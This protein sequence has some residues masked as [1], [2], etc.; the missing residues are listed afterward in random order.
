MGLFLV[1]QVKVV[2][3]GGRQSVR[4]GRG[5]ELRSSDFIWEAPSGVDL[6]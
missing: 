5:D 4:R 3:V 2:V 1:V 6:Q